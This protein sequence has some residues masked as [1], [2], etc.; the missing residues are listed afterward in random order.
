MQEFLDERADKFGNLQTLAKHMRVTFSGFLRGVKQGT[1]SPENCLRLA[2]VLG[3]EP[4]VVFRAAKKTALADQFDRLYGK[5]TN[6]MTEEERELVYRWRALTSTAREGLR[7]TMSQLPLSDAPQERT[8][9]T[10]RLARAGFPV[11]RRTGADR[12]HARAKYKGQNQRSGKDRRRVADADEGG[13]LQ[14]TS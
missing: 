13:R 2:E 10:E 6:P 14:K 4:A 1:L 7:L 3:E 9:R 11:E 8:G 5:T 12:R